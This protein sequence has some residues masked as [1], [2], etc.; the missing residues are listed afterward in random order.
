[1]ARSE[2]DPVIRA[3]GGTLGIVGAFLE[4]A[5]IATIDELAGALGI[6]GAAT[7]ETDPEQAAVIAQWVL[8]LH[9]LASARHD[10]N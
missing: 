5:N 6:Y 8:G 4:R 2:V 7:N 1:M 3:I 10:K 9:E